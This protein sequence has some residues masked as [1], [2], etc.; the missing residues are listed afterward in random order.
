MAPKFGA[1]GAAC[2]RGWRRPPPL[3]LEPRRTNGHSDHP[4]QPPCHRAT[5]PAPPPHPHPRRASRR[6]SPGRRRRSGGP[7]PAPT[8]RRPGL[9]P[10]SGPAQPRCRGSSIRP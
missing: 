2:P 1:P 5:E 10:R 6:V 8:H 7:P 4:T 9:F 3:G